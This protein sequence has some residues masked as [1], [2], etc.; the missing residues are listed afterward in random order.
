M[1]QQKS[2]PRETAK[3]KSSSCCNNCPAFAI[4]F[5]NHPRNVTAVVPV[6]APAYPGFINRLISNYTGETWKP[7]YKV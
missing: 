6:F 3:N 1:M 7:P 5:M 2:C 4:F